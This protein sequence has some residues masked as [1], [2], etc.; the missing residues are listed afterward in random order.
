MLRTYCRDAE[1]FNGDAAAGLLLEDPMA[2]PEEEKLASEIKKELVLLEI[3]IADMA[4]NPDVTI[5]QLEQLK[6][7]IEETRQ[8]IIHALKRNFN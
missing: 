4:L 5:Q 2:K 7:A 1:L 8:H 6:E 3:A